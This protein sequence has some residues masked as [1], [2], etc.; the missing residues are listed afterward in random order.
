MGFIDDFTGKSARRDLARGRQAYR[1]ELTAGQEA[2]TGEY[3][4]AEGYF[5]PYSGTG[6]R[7]NEAW[8]DAMGLN[9]PE[10]QARA[11]AAYT[12]NPIYTAMGDRA[13][14]GI[15]RGVAAS[16]QT[17]AGIQ[18]GTNALVGNY[19][20]YLNRLFAGGGMGMQAAAARAGL[21]QRAGDV[22]FTTGQQLAS[23]EQS[24]A[25]ARAAS[26]STTLNNILGVAGTAAKAIAAF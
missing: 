2:A 18:A 23:G 26:R 20:D 19:T 3:G 10:A 17:G 15:A 6:T 14:R 25:N 24:Y 4:V 22:R 11:N 21:R 12:A 5:D 8:A 16:G 13:L 9:G 1:A 7:A